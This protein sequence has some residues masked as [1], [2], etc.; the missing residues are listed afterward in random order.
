M[1]F[2]EEIDTT[3]CL[4]VAHLEK[5]KRAYN[6]VSHSP[7]RRGATCIKEHSEELAADLEFVAQH[8]GD[9]ARYREKYEQ[10]FLSWLS[11]Q[12]NCFSVMI[13]GGSGFNNTKHAKANAREHKASENF[14]E[15][16]ERTKAAILSAE[17][18]EARK[19]IDPIQEA[20]ANAEMERKTLETMKAANKIIKSK[21]AD[22]LD[23]LVAIGIKAS[24]AEELL[25]PDY[26]GRHGFA[27]FSLTNCR[28]R[29]KSWEEKAEALKKNQVKEANEIEVAGVRIVQNYQDSRIELYFEGKPDDKTRNELKSNGFRWTPSKG[30]WQGYNT[31]NTMYKL[32]RFVIPH[33]KGL[34]ETA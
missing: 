34:G 3:N 4:L 10:Y 16:R 13:T 5:A 14:R 33:L 27:S 7:D 28:N 1:L 19:D 8:G 12:G 6:W 24:A 21:S 23:E 22:K 15:W 20:L 29:M 11:A 26:A 31:N 18:K 32:Q 25:K 30:C 9:V 17:R 2:K